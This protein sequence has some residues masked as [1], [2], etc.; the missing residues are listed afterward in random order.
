MHDFVSW[1]TFLAYQQLS[2]IDV[3]FAVF[4][5]VCFVVEVLTAALCRHPLDGGAQLA[6]LT[7]GTLEEKGGKPTV[8]TIPP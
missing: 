7:P 8:G 5:S 2:L 1:Q 6:R 3:I 4:G